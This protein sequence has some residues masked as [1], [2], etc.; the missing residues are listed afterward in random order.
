MGAS[1]TSSSSRTVYFQ[2][3]GSTLTCGS[4]TYTS[5]E[6]L[7]AVISST[8]NQYVLEVSGGSFSSGCDSA[9]ARVTSNSQNV[10]AP[11]DG[12]DLV[13]WAGWASGYGTVSISSTC[14]LSA[15]AATPTSLPIPAPSKRP[16]PA[17]TKLPVPAPSKLP[18]PAPSKLPAPA[19]SKVPIP[20]PSKL[21][22][23]PSP[24]PEATAAPTKQP[25]NKP[26]T[27]TPT[28]PAPTIPGNNQPSKVPTTS[29]TKGDT[30]QVAVELSVT[31]S[32]APTNSDES[33]LK[34]T[35]ATELS[36]DSST[37]RDFVVTST[38]TARRLRRFLLLSVVGE[39][40]LASSYTWTV[41]FSIVV[42]LSALTDDSITSASAFESTVQKSLSSGLE[43][44]LSAAGVE[45]T[46]ESV[47]AS[48]PESDGNDDDGS[49]AGAIIVTG[50]AV[51]AALLLGLIA[52]Q[53]KKRRFLES[54]KVTSAA[55]P[56][57]SA[58]VSAEAPPEAEE[59]QVEPPAT[60]MEKSAVA[61]EEFDAEAPAVKEEGGTAPVVPLSSGDVAGQEE[62]TGSVE[63][64]AL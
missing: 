39:R 50:I 41:S 15:A 36:V 37:I 10:V 25:T 20:A 14:T 40:R 17:P 58:S 18:V 45:V 27:R 12:S 57:A 7:T 59:G 32:A 16:I 54:A 47:E 11:T 31:A 6:T 51:G 22:T 60:D 26:S 55:A 62:G 23:P 29:P 48:N 9:D 52:W 53:L 33:T 63:F 3:S 19:P 64:V 61:G 5:G 42:S 46:V 8:S 4:D 13:L 35:I 56:E 21:P 24:T 34:T 1:A 43:D 30:V 44:A 2:R 49:S 28:T 38:E